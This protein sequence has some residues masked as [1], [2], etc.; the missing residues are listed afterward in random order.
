MTNPERISDP[1]LENL[2]SRF[3]P[4]VLRSTDGGCWTWIGAG[5]TGKEYGIISFNRGTIKAHRAS[6]MLNVG[7]IPPG[8]RVLHKCDNPACVNPDHLFLGTQAD[9]MSD[10]WAKNRHPPT[11]LR[12]ERNPSAKLTVSSVRFIRSSN[13]SCDQLAM[14]LGVS[15][16]TVR[17][18]K[19]GVSWKDIS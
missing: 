8:M 17:A 18:A 6:Y 7:P 15:V 12:G 9:N 3:E 5:A 13:M 16:S 4:K 19:N 10:M 14:T 11:G 2:R 1:T